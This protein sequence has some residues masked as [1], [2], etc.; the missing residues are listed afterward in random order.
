MRMAVK[1]PVRVPISGRDYEEAARILDS[2]KSFEEEPVLRLRGLLKEAISEERFEDAARHQDELNE[3]APHSLLKCSSNA[4][5]LGIRA[6][7][8]SVYIEGRSQPSKGQYFFAYR[9]KITNDSDC[10]VQLLRRHWI[11]TDANEKIENVW[12]IGVIA[13]QPVMPPRMGFE[14]SSACPLSTPNGRM[15]GDFEMKHMIEWTFTLVTIYFG[16][17]SFLSMRGCYL[18]HKRVS[19]DKVDNVEMNA[20]AVMLTDCVFWFVI[21]PFFAIKDYHLTALVISMHSMN[22]ILLL[23]DTAL[24]CMRFPWFRIAYFYIWTIT[25]LLFQW[26]VHACVR[27]WW[28]YP[29]LDL[30]SPYAPLWYKL[31]TIIFLQR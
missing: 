19:G 6:Q 27:L 3:I 25:Y 21:V 5:N 8:R 7:V 24:N 23:G 28:P 1:E 10:P 26:L 18:Y 22:A 29:F 14:Y 12:G 11:I 13:E 17:G 31:L 30:S 4:T 15:E 16:L 9:I 2:L 20:G